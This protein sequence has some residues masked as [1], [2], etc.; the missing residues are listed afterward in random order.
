MWTYWYIF[1]VVVGYGISGLRNLLYHQ[2]FLAIQLPCCCW[3]ASL[4]RLQPKLSSWPLT[5]GGRKAISAEPAAKPTRL[6]G[7]C[8]W[9]P[10]PC[11]S[12]MEQGCLH[13]VLL[14]QTRTK[15]VW[16][17]P[18]CC[19]SSKGT[20]S[21]GHPQKPLVLW[22]RWCCGMPQ[23]GSGRYGAESSLGWAPNWM[24]PEEMSLSSFHPGMLSHPLPSFWKRGFGGSSERCVIIRLN[25]NSSTPLLLKPSIAC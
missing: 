15:T 14:D 5:P 3:E 8:S 10:F 1:V 23:D 4:P 25:S 2:D 21:L 16:Q 11:Y 9:S 22:P 19:P 17:N 18:L 7:R 20:E 12:R 6:A 24:C 13:W